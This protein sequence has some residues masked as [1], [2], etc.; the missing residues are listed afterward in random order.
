MRDPHPC[1]LSPIQSRY[2]RRDVIFS[3]ILVKLI[4]TELLALGTQRLWKSRD[5]M[6][7]VASTSNAPSLPGSLAQDA[8]G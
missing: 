6:G 5:S 4:K 8:L 1:S 2:V 7:S 3:P